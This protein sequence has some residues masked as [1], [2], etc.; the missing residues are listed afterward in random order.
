MED[1]PLPVYQHIDAGRIRL[2]TSQYASPSLI[3][4]KKGPAAL[5]R[6]VCNYRKL[7]SLTVR[8]RSPLPNVDKLVRMVATGKFFSILDQTNTFFQ[9]RMRE[10]DIPLTAVKTPWGLMEWCV[11]PMGLTN[12]PA[13]HQARLEEALGDLINKICVV[14]LEDIVVYSQSSKQH[15]SHVRAVLNWSRAANLYCSPK[16]TFLFRNKVKFL[17]HYISADGIRPDGEKVEAVQNWTSPK[18]PKGVKKFLGTV[19]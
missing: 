13:T 3:I 5:P 6:W 15:E 19:Q 8:D 16:K 12:A 14:Y 11:M 9:T 2:S 10:E 1:P 17:G 4:P 18:S 7:N